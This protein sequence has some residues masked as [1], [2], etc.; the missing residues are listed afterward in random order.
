MFAHDTKK[1]VV[2]KAAAVS[3]DCLDSSA[4][5]RLSQSFIKGVY[6]VPSVDEKKARKRLQSFRAQRRGTLIVCILQSWNS[7]LAYCKV[8]AIF[9][10]IQTVLGK[11]SN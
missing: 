7:L 4:E 11:P 3:I 8:A 10:S 1:A 9:Q 5:L 2:K 6:V